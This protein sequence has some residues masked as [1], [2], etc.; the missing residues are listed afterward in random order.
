MLRKGKG[1]SAVAVTL[2]KCQ[3]RGLQVTLAG[4]RVG[5]GLLVLRPLTW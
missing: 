5:W 3:H 1:L 2:P 4:Q